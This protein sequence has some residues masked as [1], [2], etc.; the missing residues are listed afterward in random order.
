MKKSVIIGVVIFMVI[1]VSFV[2]SQEEVIRLVIENQGGDMEGHTPRGFQG[3]GTGLF[4]G[5]NLNPG[6]PNG[7]GVQIYLS[8]DLKDVP[9]GE[10][11]S[12]VLKSDDVSFFGEPFE[13][14]G[15]LEIEEVRYDSFSSALWN[16]EAL[17]DG[18]RCVFA[19]S[20]EGDFECD[21]SSAVQRSFDDNYMYVQ[22]R[23]LFDEAG[24]GDGVKDMA[25]FFKTNSNTNE[26]GIFELDLEIIS[27][28]VLDVEESENYLFL[29]IVM[30]MFVILF[31]I[32]LSFIRKKDRKR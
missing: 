31:L 4:V 8:F 13:G 15:I 12:A 21:L 17:V 20:K 9:S 16:L 26:P 18:A 3:Q 11:V 29:F 5:D 27:N 7:D 30:A 24:D 22:F 2:A 14:L 25:M 1:L 32:Y 19:D 23:V 28:D 10:I 6:F